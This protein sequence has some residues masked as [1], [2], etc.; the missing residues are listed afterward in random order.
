MRAFRWIAVALFVAS[1]ASCVTK[2]GSGPALP[3]QG[4]LANGASQN[5]ATL[6]TGF[7]TEQRWGPLSRN[8]WEPTVAADPSSSWV[9]QMTTPQRPNY[10]LFRSSP[11]GGVTWNRSREVCRRGMN[12]NWQYDPQ[13]AVAPDG[14]VDVVC[15]DTFNPGVVFTQSHDRGKTF[16]T[17]VRLDGV[18]SYSDKPTLVV[19]PNAKDV[20]VA[21]NDRFRLLVAA[22]HDGGATWQPAVN[23][24]KRKLWYYSFSGTVTPNGSVWFAVDGEAGKNQTGAGYIAVVTSADGG[25]TWRTIDLGRT[26]EGEPC[27][28]KFCYPDF[29]TGEAAVASDSSGA[30]VFAYASNKLRQGPNSL[31]VRRSSDGTQWSAPIAMATAGNSTSPALA[32]GPSAGDFRL[33]WQDNRNGAYAWNTWYSRSTDGGA[34]WSAD[35]RLSDR[36]SGA[37][38]KNRNGY[39]W[40]FGDYLGLAVDSAGV[41][42]VVWGEGSGVYVPGGTWFTRGE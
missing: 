31:Y 36:G 3:Q 20:Y 41:N 27:K 9:Y 10:L 12:P 33:V 11:D 7:E 2:N 17:S 40:P 6:A 29:Y 34:T 15:L 8:D 22:S 21:F 42:Y 1:T 13:V 14:T 26:H 39:D 5:G 4:N 38:Y 28:T 35:L 24:T 30:L 16:S 19:S 18:R 32:S 37:K 23:A 25:S